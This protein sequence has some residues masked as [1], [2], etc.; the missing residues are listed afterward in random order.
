MSS[1][2]NQVP[3]AHFSEMNHYRMYEYLS[4]NNCL[5]PCQPIVYGNDVL[6][7]LSYFVVNFFIASAKERICLSF[8]S[9]MRR[10]CVLGN[11]IVSNGHVAQ[12]GTTTIQ[13]SFS[14]TMR[15]YNENFYLLLRVCWK[16]NEPKEKIF[17]RENFRLCLCR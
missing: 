5:L 6:K 9:F 2:N 13:S 15:T 14:T 4:L 17:F 10:I 12:N 7:I 16:I 8:S 1:Q 11:I 3:L